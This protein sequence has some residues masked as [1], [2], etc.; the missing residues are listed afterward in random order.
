MK[1]QVIAIVAEVGETLIIQKYSG[2]ESTTLGY[3]YPGEV[4]DDCNAAFFLPF[5][6]FSPQLYG[7]I[8]DKQKLY[9]LGCKM[10]W[11][12]IHIHWEMITTIKL[13]S[14]FINR[15]SYFVCVMRTLS[16]YSFKK[17]QVHNTGLLTRV[18]M[19]YVRFPEH[20]HLI[21]A[22][23]GIFDRKNERSIV[24]GK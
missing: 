11:F 5:F 2:V 17:F 4:K 9:I 23:S 18:T 1:A 24:S 13:I 7:G 8:F 10:W 16:I 19:V 14:I 3:W 20:I 22:S 15:H 21:T 12:N 6:L